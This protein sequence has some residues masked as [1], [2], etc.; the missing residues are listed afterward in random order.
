VVK[1][2]GLLSIIIAGTLAGIG[3][4]NSASA[5][6]QTS[7]QVWS[8]QT[9]FGIVYGL[10]PREVVD[11]PTTRVGGTIVVSTGQRRLYY[12]LGGGKAI[13]YGIAVGMEGYSWSG[14]STVSAKREWPDWSPTPGE[15]KRFPNLPGHMAGGPDN[16]LGARALYLGD[17]LYRI[18]GT[19]EPWKL[20][21]GVS[22]G[23]IRMSN[24][25]ITD[26]YNRAKIG[27]TVIVQR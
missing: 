15:L 5:A 11:Y 25:D 22:S 8:L 2:I 18:H 9:P 20:G 14:V 19:N 16:P 23:C 24:D 27:A 10:I 1:I 6:S 13:R 3:G 17:T 12:V 26:L 7:G 4:A 21:G